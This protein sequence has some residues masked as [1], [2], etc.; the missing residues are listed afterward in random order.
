M[1]IDMLGNPVLPGEPRVE[2]AV[3]D[4]PRHFL[5]ADQHA[6][7]LGIVDRREVRTRADVDVEPRSGEQLHRRI[8][9]GSFGYAEFQ[10]HSVSRSWPSAGLKSG[11]TSRSSVLRSFIPC[12][13]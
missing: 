4:V 6:L 3:R 13:V 1:A 5:R 7:D 10:F 9:E 8:L 2:H 11:S 12:P